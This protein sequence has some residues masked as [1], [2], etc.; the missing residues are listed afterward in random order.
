[1]GEHD[2][3]MIYSHIKQLADLES[4]TK[5][6]HKRI[7]ALLVISDSIQS[8]V[9]DF[10][11]LVSTV[12]QQGKDITQVVSF[13]AKQEERV[14]H[15]EQQMSDKNTVE[16]LHDR[17]DLTEKE[18]KLHLEQVEKTNEG[19]ILL[20]SERV[21]MVENKDKDEVYNQ[22]KSMKKYILGGAVAIGTALLLIGLGIV[23]MVIQTGNLPG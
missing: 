1:M 11:K 22:W 17:L 8:L 13:F 12:E 18:Y 21:R 3:V 14:D 15:M 2:E 19:H 20:L 5:S 6:A 7:D 23:W 9:I 4:S 10:N 16:R